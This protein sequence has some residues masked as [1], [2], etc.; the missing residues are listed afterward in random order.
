MKNT[1]SIFTYLYFI[2]FVAVTGKTFTLK[3][4]QTRVIMVASLSLPHETHLKK[5]DIFGLIFEET[6]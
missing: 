6:L 4:T 1:I 3:N 5:R 2:L